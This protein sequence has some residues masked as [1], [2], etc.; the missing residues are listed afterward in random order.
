M[1]TIPNQAKPVPAGLWRRFFAFVI[2]G[3][4]VSIPCFVLVEVFSNFFLGSPTVAKLLGFAITVGYFSIF[5]SELVEGQTFGMMALRLKVVERDGSTVSVP[6]SFLRYTILFFPF[7][8]SSGLLSPRVPA[9]VAYIYETGLSA[10]GIVILYLGVFNRRTGQSLHD[11]ATNTFVVGSPGAG[12]VEAQE[13]WQPHWAFIVGLF[14]LGFLAQGYVGTATL[15]RT[16]PTMS[17]L[18]DIQNSVAAAT[19]VRPLNVELK[20]SQGH[21]GI[22][23]SIVC[24]GISSDHDN[25][26]I[27]IAKTVLAADTQAKNLD[28][29]TIDCATTLSIGL[30]TSTTHEPFTHTP[31]EW[32]RIISKE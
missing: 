32:A 6:L 11:L 5:G 23:V 3:I 19:H 9:F 12:P 20:S 7:L 28:Y 31:H 26:A 18:S 29:I 14:V 30:F 21:S 25:V 8:L 10:A 22:V 16:S 27:N 24:D 2:D 1:E 17:E 13:F 4:L 15:A